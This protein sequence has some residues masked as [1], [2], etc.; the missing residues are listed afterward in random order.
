M[1]VARK[2]KPR[3][4]IQKVRAE[5]QVQTRQRIVEAAVKLHLERG[6]AHTS[7]AAIAER[8]GVNRV[9]VYRHFPDARSLFE[10]CSEHNRKVNPPPDMTPWRQIADPR[11]RTE[12][13]LTQL[14]DYFR[15][16]ED[17]WAN[18][19]R[20]AEIEPIVKEMA[21]KKRMAYL[22][23][24]RDVLLVG[25]PK[26]RTRGPLLR[27]VLGLAVDFRTWQTLV[28]REGLE[29]RTA[30]ALMVRLAGAIGG[31]ADRA[32]VLERTA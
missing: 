4:Y 18:I 13:A 22:R 31:S 24:V 27:A 6:P 32:E 5:Q 10:A 11:R 20:D 28:R 3:P 8:A 17:G 25:Y 2:V 12:L 15:R 14:Y 30:V 16:N 26:R 1:G 7:I 21:E 19:L 9:T 23:E 29:D